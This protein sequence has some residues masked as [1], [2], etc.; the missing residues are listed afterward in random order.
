MGVAEALHHAHAH[1][2]IHR[3]VK[4][5]NIM[6]LDSGE[7]KVMDF[8]I[9]KVESSQL[10]AA[11]Q[12]IGTP[13]YMSPEQAL[14]RPLDARSDLFSLGSLAY[15]LLTGQQAFGGSSVPR[16]IARVVHE[17]PPPPT[18]VVRGLPTDVDY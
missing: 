5:A 6:M 9:A 13:L 15:G 14:G 4:P 7:T 3:D 10:T 1:G 12:F 17:D 11:G 16:I 2:V 18:R 8:G